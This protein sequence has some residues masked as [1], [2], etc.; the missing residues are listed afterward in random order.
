MHRNA[1]SNYMLW[2]L[3]VSFLGRLTFCLKL[4]NHV[5]LGAALTT[6]QNLQNDTHVIAIKREILNAIIKSIQT[7]QVLY[8]DSQDL[9]NAF[10][11]SLL[12]HFVYV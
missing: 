7:S 2:Y 3:N 4:V 11:Y 12:S 8:G 6:C 1:T 5:N 10:C 9:H